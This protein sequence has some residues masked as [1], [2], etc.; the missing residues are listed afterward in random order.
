MTETYLEVV[1]L[2]VRA[3][4]LVFAEPGF[5]LKGGTAINLF[6]RDM[7]RLSV[8]L[9][10]V[11]LDTGLARDE[12]LAAISA[13]VHAMAERV[14]RA[15]MTAHVPQRAAGDEAKL[16]I[17]QGRAEVKVE[18]NQV[19]RGALLPVAPL[20]LVDAARDVLKA[21]L[22]LPVLAVD[23]LYAGKLVA[24]FDRQ[25]PRDWFDVQ[26]L[27]EH[28]GIT[29]GMRRCFVAYLA[30]HN[31]PLHE[32]LFGNLQPM[33]GVFERE[34]AGMS[35]LPVTLAELET[36]R[37]EVFRELPAML[38]AA[39]RDFLLSLVRAEPAWTLLGLPQ[40]EHMPAVR[41]KLTNLQ[42]LRRENR[43]KFD[44]QAALLA[45]RLAG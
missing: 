44:E 23:E 37:A 18:I 14:Q 8:D 38:D 29:P 30:A 3:A 27:R 39:E 20:R 31:R 45:A 36:T 16:L 32:V 33:A 19:M 10:L 25:H 42:R 35:L 1:R 34:F 9:D 12:A 7:P 40:L 24:A 5:A 26:R 15:G 11:F 21:D 41:W 22:R 28:G 6:V 2:L 17:R 13:G 4:P 43:R